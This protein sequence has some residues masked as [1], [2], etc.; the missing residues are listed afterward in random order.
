MDPKKILADSRTA[1]SKAVEHTLHEFSTLH[2]GKATP[3]MVESVHVEAYGS[4]VRLKE[5]AAITTPDARTIQIQPWDKGLLRDVEKAIQVAKL[6]FNPVVQG[7]LVRCP[8]PEL[9]RERRQDLAKVAHTQAEDGRVRIR[10]IRREAND[11]LK[12]AKTAGQISEDDLKR[13][14]KDVQVEHDKFIAEIN[15]H[16]AAKEA[17]LLKV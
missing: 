9:S 3:N 13:S 1:M 2:T 10:T 16:L 8:V 7:D 4:T 15:K 17:D 12:K 5:I 14:E 6:G 11:V